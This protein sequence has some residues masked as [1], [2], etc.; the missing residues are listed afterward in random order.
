[1][2][3]FYGSVLDGQLENVMRFAFL[4]FLLLASPAA[5]RT[6]NLEAQG[7]QY[8]RGSC[9]NP[10]GSRIAGTVDHAALLKS[11]FAQ[12][13]WGDEYIIPR[14]WPCFYSKIKI[15]SGVLLKGQGAY[16]R[17]VKAY[18]PSDPY[19]IFFELSN[20]AAITDVHLFG[21]DGTSGGVG[22]GMVSSPEQDLS[23]T[24]VRNTKVTIQN[25]G[26]W[27]GG[28][29]YD[30]TNGPLHYGQRDN[31][32]ET[33]L[34][35]NYECFGFKIAGQNSSRFSNIDAVNKGWNPLPSTWIA[36]FWLTGKKE[37][38]NNGISIQGSSSDH[39]IVEYT[40]GSTLS[41]GSVGN[42]RFGSSCGS[43][44][45]VAGYFNSTPIFEPGAANCVLY[46][47]K[48]IFKSDQ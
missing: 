29:I 22:I 48:Y 25:N 17:A 41:F 7:G 14:G 4:T 18:T 36:D 23:S 16:S 13:D 40:S 2:L 12:G 31:I 15:P 39:T 32:V 47:G 45:F 8:N 9:V 19:E 33:A 38:Y 44:Q 28:F 6:I 42:L 26:K 5:A 30:G 20:S 43:V 21:A 24:R 35:T 27:C 46:G 1:V 10:D 37:N 11:L 3:R 34:I